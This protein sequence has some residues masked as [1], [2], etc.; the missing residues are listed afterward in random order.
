MD[1]RRKFD[2]RAVHYAASRPGYAK[3]LID[4]LYTQWGMSEASVIADVGSGTGKLAEQLLERGSHV[5]AVEPNQDMRHAAEQALGDCERFCSVCGGAEDTDLE[6]GCA[7]FVT[8]AQAFHWFDGERFKAECQRIL[9]PGGRVFLIWNMREPEDAVNQAL[10]EVYG[11]FCPAFKGFSEG[12][13]KDDPRIRAFFGGAYAYEAYDHPLWYDRETFIARCLSSSYSLKAG[14][15][16]YAAYIGA[17]NE[18]FDVHARDG[19]MVCIGNSS[20]VYTGKV[21]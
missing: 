7:D 17:L 8:A 1:T 5:Y 12:M 13:V 18:L 20:V 16:K 15:E 10:Q 11:R 3:A 9:R 4:C 14:D 19:I 21:E 6:K 2:G